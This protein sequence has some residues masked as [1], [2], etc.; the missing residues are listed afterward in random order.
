MMPF[1]F[2]VSHPTG[3]QA[4]GTHAKLHLNGRPWAHPTPLWLQSW[5]TCKPECLITRAPSLHCRTESSLPLQALQV[6]K[7][8]KCSSDWKWKALL[9]K[10]ILPIPNPWS[11]VV[12]PQRV[13]SSTSAEWL[14]KFENLSTGQTKSRHAA[15]DAAK[16]GCEGTKEAECSSTCTPNVINAKSYNYQ[17]C[18][19]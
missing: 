1:E 18:F 16:S 3:L 9:R 19:G 15:V 12:L 5:H 10:S 11:L 8:M 17:H 4:Q 2:A 13:E 6:G 14:S 7:R